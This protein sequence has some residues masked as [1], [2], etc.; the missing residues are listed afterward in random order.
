MYVALF[1]KYVN[2]FLFLLALDCVLYAQT[3]SKKVL[4]FIF[5]SPS[6]YV[7]DIPFYN[8]HVYHFALPCIYDH[9]HKQGFFFF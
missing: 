7:F 6:F 4:I 2:P 8:L 1:F 9:F 3:H 5:S